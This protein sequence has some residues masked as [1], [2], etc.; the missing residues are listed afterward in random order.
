[1]PAENARADIRIG[2]IVKFF[3]VRRIER[4][5]LH[6]KAVFFSECFDHRGIGVGDHDLPESFAERDCN[7]ASDKSVGVFVDS[8]SVSDIHVFRAFAGTERNDFGK[9]IVP[10]NTHIQ[11]LH[12]DNASAQF[13]QIRFSVIFQHTVIPALTAEELVPEKY[14]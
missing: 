1:M 5:P 9:Y 12:R 14:F 4:Q 7:T 11:R 2:H 3:P 8:E 10:V 6:L 13:F